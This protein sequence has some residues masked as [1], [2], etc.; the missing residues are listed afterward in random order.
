MGCRRDLF[1]RKTALRGPSGG[2]SALGPAGELMS[3]ADVL[4]DFALTDF[5]SRL[6]PTTGAVRTRWLSGNSAI[7]FIFILF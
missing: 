2:S 7:P 6:F 5:L 3:P 4:S 1:E